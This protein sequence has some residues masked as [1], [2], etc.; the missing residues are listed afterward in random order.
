MATIRF[1]ESQRHIIEGYQGGLMGI[2]AV[3]GS[4]KTFTLS[5]LAAKLVAKVALEGRDGQEVL[6]VTFSNSAVNSFKSR[7]ADILLRD[8]NMLP[9]VGYR[10]R[11]L[12]GLAHDIVRERPGLLGLPEDFQILD[13]SISSSIM[14][15]VVESL[16]PTWASLTESYLSPDLTEREL[17]KVRAVD[18]PEQMVGAVSRFI[19]QAKDLQ[20]TPANLGQWYPSAIPLVQFGIECYARYHRT[21]AYRGAVDFDDLIQLALQALQTDEQYL[22][23]L[24]TRWVYV[25][26]DEAQDSSLL[27]EK[28]LNLLTGRRNWVRVGDPNQAINTTFTTANAS[29]LRQ[30]LAQKDVQRRDLPTS[31]R[32]ATPIIDLA[33]ELV[34]WATQA[35]PVQESREAFFEQYIQPTTPDDPQKNPLAQDSRIYI[36]SLDKTPT[37]DQELEIV[38]NSLNRYLTEN[39]TKTVA[40]LAPENSRGFKMAERLREAGIPYHEL[41][42]SS[43]EV[44]RTAFFLSFILLYL[45]KPSQASDLAKLYRDV[46]YELTLKDTGYNIEVLHKYIKS[47]THLENLLFPTSPI[48]LQEALN[49]PLEFDEV[50]D[51][52]EDFLRFVRFCLEA[53]PLPIDQLIL[54]ISQRLFTNPID[55]ALSYKIAVV[56]RSIQ[57]ANP[58]WGLPELIAELDSIKMNQRRFIGFEDASQG[59][60]PQPGVATVATMHASKGLEW[61][62]VY[63]L[64]VSNYG[65]PSLQ[66]YDKYV[67]EK[68]FLRDQLNLEAEM[69]AGLQALQNGQR[70][71]E[72]RATRQARVDYVGER[73]RLL[74]VAITRARSDLSIL[75]NIGRP[76]FNPDGAEIRGNI[77][78]LPVVQVGSALGY[79]SNATPD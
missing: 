20:L 48:N 70:Y 17:K 69:L 39:P 60:E 68:W 58:G 54:T 47:Q 57:E 71:T 23:R 66:S 29:F 19:K 55:I 35:H 63:L 22:K 77:L 21:L 72:K 78:A 6:I 38:V 16:L 25:L 64:A 61:D 75:W 52:F 36:H 73:L 13:E 2:S 3:P 51:N 45:S 15:E 27:Q 49:E 46:W 14:R 67:A 53:L 11:T 24:Q 12:H 40:V 65:F 4:G 41:L 31:G 79:I 28:M 43:S 37:P 7:I 32:S 18:M 30:F 34:R 42:R 8:Q 10:V 59:Y 33:N 62:R 74:Y 56:L 26:E 76:T 5:H 50:I 44:R 9:F 1:R